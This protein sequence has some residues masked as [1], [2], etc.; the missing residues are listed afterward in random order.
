M[1]KE[2]SSL[3]WQVSAILE[4]REIVLGVGPLQKVSES[5]GEWCPYAMNVAGSCLDV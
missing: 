1:L 3:F 2:V 4:Y 5:F